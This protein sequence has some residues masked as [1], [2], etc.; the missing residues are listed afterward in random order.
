MYEILTDM[1]YEVKVEESG[2]KAVRTFIEHPEEFDLVLTELMMFDIMGDEIA[3][4]IRF[5]RPDMP[6]VAMTGTPD[7]LPL[8]RRRLRGSV[9][10]S[11]KALT[12][13]ELREGLQGIVSPHDCD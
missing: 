5:I 13:A 11:P 6:V 3:R 12:R 9:R 2:Q 1:G 4:R 10:C 7:N 8:G